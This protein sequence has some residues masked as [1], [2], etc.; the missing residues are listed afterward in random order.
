MS[1]LV[2]WSVGLFRW[3]GWYLGCCAD[4]FVY[5]DRWAGYLGWCAG[6]LICSDGWSGV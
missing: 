1:G 4:R 3:V 5:L 6:L 2:C